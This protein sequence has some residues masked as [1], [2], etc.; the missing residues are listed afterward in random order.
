MAKYP[1]SQ[2]II[3]CRYTSNIIFG[4]SINNDQL[5]NL[6]TKRSYDIVL[7]TIQCFK[8]VIQT[9]WLKME[10]YGNNIYTSK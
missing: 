2:F 3:L 4:N 7:M 9:S 8:N 10:C 6:P 1:T 5:G